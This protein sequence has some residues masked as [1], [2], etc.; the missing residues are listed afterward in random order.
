MRK[1]FQ[2]Q[3]IPTLTC[4]LLVINLTVSALSCILIEGLGGK[5]C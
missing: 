1:A 3:P 5:L 4:E 2:G